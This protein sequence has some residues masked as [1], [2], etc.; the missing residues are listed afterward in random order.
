MAEGR[1]DTCSGRQ[2]QATASVYFRGQETPLTDIA[3]GYEEGFW[4]GFAQRHV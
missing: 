4:G 2:A 1:A 3:Y